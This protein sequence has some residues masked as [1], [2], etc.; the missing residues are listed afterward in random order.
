MSLPETQAPA[1]NASSAVASP[2][3]LMATIGRFREVVGSVFKEVRHP[4]SQI[5]KLQQVCLIFVC[6][7]A[8]RADGAS[9]AYVLI[10]MHFSGYVR[11]FGVAD[12][13]ALLTAE[14]VCLAH[15]RGNPGQSC[16]TGQ[17][18]RGLQTWQRCGAHSLQSY[19]LALRFSVTM[20]RSCIA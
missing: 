9:T 1:N 15:C 16:S 20:W 2:N 18:F 11:V 14:K 8:S 4:A 17:L 13:P 19:A 12:H 7:L 10:M 3:P 5:Q 6:M